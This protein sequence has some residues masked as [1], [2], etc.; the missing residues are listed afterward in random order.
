M[1]KNYSIIIVL[2]SIILSTSVH[3]QSKSPAEMAESFLQ[4]FQNGKISDAY[5]KLFIGSSIP[6]SNDIKTTSCPDAKD[7]DFKRASSIWSYIRL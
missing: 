3:A 5:D 6:T 7:A 1:I 4:M 2:F